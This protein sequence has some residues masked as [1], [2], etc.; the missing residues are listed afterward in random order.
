MSRAHISQSGKAINLVVERTD[1]SN[2]KKNKLKRA[3]NKRV[4]KGKQIL[5]KTP[6]WK[7]R[8][9]H[10]RM[11]SGDYSNY[12]G[13]QFRSPYVAALVTHQY[14]DSPMWRGELTNKLLIM[15]EQGVGDEIL[16][17]SIIPEAL[18][19]AREVI[20][21]CDARLIP[22]FQRS[23]PR[24]TCVPR[25]EEKID[26]ALPRWNAYKADHWILL[27]DLA[28]L[29]RRKVEYF[30]GKPFL[31]PLP[32][33]KYKDR[34]GISWRGR[35]GEY[36]PHDFE[37]KDPLS[38]QYDLRWDE[39]VEV[40]DIDLRNDLEGVF[41]LCSSLKKVVCVSTSVAHIA[42]SIGT[43]VDLVL[44]PK[45]TGVDNRLNWRWGLGSKTP[46][47]KSVTVYQSLNEY[48]RMRRD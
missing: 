18:V 41:S 38:L 34:I 35:M 30:P 8:L 45:N 9:C 42:A 24:L 19:R 47:Y 13:W 22:I 44:A 12:D 39:D 40:P 46:W 37:I 48:L 33:D 29:F 26:E 27:A 21:E 31:K 10:A 25:T 2:L 36:K 11:L 3:L 23:F 28:M 14:L 7:N 1:A 16:F 32:S 43:P 4:K 17:A 15:A 6:E 20:F 5:P